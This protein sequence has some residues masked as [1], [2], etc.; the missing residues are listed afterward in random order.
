MPLQR[1]RIAGY[2]SIRDLRFEFD[3][4]TLIVGPNGCGKTNLYRSLYLAHRAAEG[5]L[6]RA[7]AEEGGMPS[8]LWAGERRKGPVRLILEVQLEDLEYRLACGLPA[9]RG[10]FMLDPE[11]KEE[12]VWYRDGPRRLCMMERPPVRRRSLF[13]KHRR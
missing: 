12:Q 3:D 7:L 1:L 4:V 13:R 2:R 5:R 10:A 8:V 9:L 6:A 11:V